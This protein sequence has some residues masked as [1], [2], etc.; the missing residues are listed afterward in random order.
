MSV[1]I[2]P[3]F[4]KKK[5]LQILWE[6]NGTTNLLSEMSDALRLRLCDKIILI[7]KIN[8]IVRTYSLLAVSLYF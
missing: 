4:L 2:I 7:T 3:L 8:L 1:W 6:G 5:V